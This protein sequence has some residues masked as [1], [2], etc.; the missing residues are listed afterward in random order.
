MEAMERV[1]RTR[2][3]IHTAV[4]YTKLLL[5]EA[6]PSGLL[7]V[8]G[9]VRQQMQLLHGMASRTASLPD[10]LD[11]SDALKFEPTPARFEEALLTAYGYFVQPRS[12][13]GGGGGGSSGPSSKPVSSLGL[14][15]P[16]ST[17]QPPS[18][19]HSS[20]LEGAHTGVVGHSHGS[21]AGPGGPGSSMLS[22]FGSHH[23]MKGN[24]LTH[25]VLLGGMGNGPP[26]RDHL[27]PSSMQ[28]QQAQQHSRPTPADLNAMSG[29]TSIQE[30]NLQQ[31]ASLAGKVE[32]QPGLNLNH[33]PST[34]S[35]LLQQ[36]LMQQEQQQHQQLRQHLQQQQMQQL[37][38]H[39]QQQQQQ[40]GTPSPHTAAP[41]SPFMLADLLSGDMNNMQAL[42]N[43]QALAKLGSHGKS[44]R[45]IFS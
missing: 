29:M 12:G 27:S 33:H 41:V 18:P 36:Q 26:P 39:Q 9:T 19:T 11:A 28:Q 7:S 17:P 30:Y 15:T 42:S 38:R 34:S 4:R 31:L 2:D 35:L 8:A 3:R 20:P 37:Q 45:F 5:S 21:S 32:C 43:L 6:E 13:S 22:S 25:S 1:D 14:P 16:S 40:R 23:L 24:D 44:T 10:E